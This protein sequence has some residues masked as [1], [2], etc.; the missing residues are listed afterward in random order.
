VPTSPAAACR[1][2]RSR[3]SVSASG[4]EPVRST[5]PRSRPA[6]EQPTIAPGRLVAAGADHAPRARDHRDLVSTTAVGSSV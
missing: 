4:D 6:E 5:S 3:P 1:M 2:R